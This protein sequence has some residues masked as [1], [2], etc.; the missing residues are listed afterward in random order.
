MSSMSTMRTL[1]A[2]AGGFVLHG[3]GG[4][5]RLGDGQHRAV[6]R[7]WC[8]LG[9]GRGQAGR[10]QQSERDV[11]LVQSHADDFSWCSGLR[12]VVD[13]AWEG[14]SVRKFGEDLKRERHGEEQ[15]RS[16]P[17]AGRGATV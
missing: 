4:I 12:R 3:D 16:R 1:G 2:P 5:V 6:E 11:S 17:D 14:D 9:G 7:L 13:C 8:L 10:R 15:R